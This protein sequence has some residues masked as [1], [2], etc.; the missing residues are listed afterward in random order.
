MARTRRQRATS[1]DTNG[2]GKVPG[3]ANSNR[4]TPEK[5]IDDTHFLEEPQIVTEA[6]N[7]QILTP[8]DSSIF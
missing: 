5:G 8:E 4:T 2:A 3:K 1:G 6:I 7:E